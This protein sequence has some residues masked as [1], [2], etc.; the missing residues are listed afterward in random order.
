M[1]SVPNIRIAFH[2]IKTQSN[3]LHCILYT[4]S[5]V[6]SDVFYL[7]LPGAKK[8]NKLSS[9]SS[10]NSVRSKGIKLRV[11][12]DIRKHFFTITIVKY[13]NTLPREGV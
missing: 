9:G 4:F 6:Y 12:L 5:E 7:V 10:I 2:G 1:F 3:Y 13:W 8:G 11:R